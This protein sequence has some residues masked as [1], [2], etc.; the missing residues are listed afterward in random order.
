[1]A[2]G[3][4]EFELKWLDP[5][6]SENRTDKHKLIHRNNVFFYYIILVFDFLKIEIMSSSLMD[7]NVGQ[8]LLVF[9]LF[10]MRVG[11]VTLQIQWSTCAFHF[12]ISIS[13]WGF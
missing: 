9:F 4:D 3:Q 7:T 10:G 1:M 2:Q 5:R 8:Y 11:L 12:L 13:I 6:L